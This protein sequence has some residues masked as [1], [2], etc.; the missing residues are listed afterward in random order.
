MRVGVD[1]PVLVLGGRFDGRCSA[2]VRE[3][4]HA[5]IDG[6]PGDV[7]VD[8]TDVES[9]DITALRLLAGAA[10]RLE[11]AE[12]HLV[13]RGCSPTVLRVLTVRRWR[14]LFCVDR[15]VHA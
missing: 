1:G 7:V 13:L 3:A 15:P 2:Q 8:L 10:H 12:R 11:R 5:Q 9:I 4:L 14:R 6:Q